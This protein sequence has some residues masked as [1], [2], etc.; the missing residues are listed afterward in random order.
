VCRR[1]ASVHLNIDQLEEAC[2]LVGRSLALADKLDMTLERGI[3]LR[4]SGEVHLACE[5]WE[6]AEAALRESLEILREQGNQYQ[7]GETLYQLGR[8]Y[9]AE[10]GAG[11]PAGAAS[12]GVAKAELAL[13]KA[14]E[15]FKRLGA[16]RALARV[17][18]AME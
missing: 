5:A 14:K 16:A 8:L 4:V 18:E 1:Q 17:E 6:E 3:S 11:S 13:G 10:A 12:A 2:K 7:M 15:I 9:R